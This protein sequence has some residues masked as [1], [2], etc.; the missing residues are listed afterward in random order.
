M[1]LVYICATGQ[2]GFRG[3][4]TINSHLERERASERKDNLE[5]E[6]LEAADLRS[7]AA[8]WIRF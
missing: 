5:L 6:K 3:I 1:A 2:T 8:I 4:N 7:R